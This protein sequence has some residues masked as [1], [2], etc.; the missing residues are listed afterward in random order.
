M[1]S[2]YLNWFNSPLFHICRDGTHTFCGRVYTDKGAIM[3]ADFYPSLGQICYTC[4]DNE[5]VDRLKTGT[6]ERN[7][8]V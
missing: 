7:D 2:R 6:P 4:R 1:L 8:I 5:R 3:P